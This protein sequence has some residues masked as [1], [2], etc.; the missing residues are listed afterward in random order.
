MCIRDRYIILSFGLLFSVNAQEKVKQEVKVVKPYEPVIG[1]AFKISELPK[2]VDT[3]KVKPS[4]DYEIAPVKHS[5]SFNPTPIK[6]ARLISEPLSKLY[7]GYAKAGFGSYLSPLAEVYVGSKRS[8]KW[9]WNGKIHYN[10]SNGKIKNTAG[11]KVYAGLSNT[12]A[13]F[14]ASHFFKSEKTLKTGI[15][16]GN[17]I[18]YYYGFDP[19]KVSELGIDAPLL[20]ED[21]EHQ[22]LNIV[23][24]FAQLQ[25]NYLDSSRV[26][27]Q[28]KIN[29]QTLSG[30]NEL[31]EH[32]MDI[33]TSLDYFFEN[34]FI[35]ADVDL[36]YINNQGIEDSI[37]AGIFRFSPWVGAF[38]NKWRIVA[39]V[40]TFFDQA[41]EEYKFYPRIS[42]HYNVIDYFLIPYFELGGSY[43]ENSYLEI[44]N[45]NPFIKQNLGVSPSD[46]K[47]NMTFGFRGNISSKVAFNA[48]IDY[49]ITNNQYF[50]VIDTSSQLHNKFVTVS[51]TITRV[52]LLG[53]ISYKTSERLW[54]AVK[55]NYYKYTM[56][57]QLEPWHMPTFDIS[58]NARYRIQNKITLD[59]N[60][61]GIGTRYA[62]DFD[63]NNQVY[64]KE[65][66][67]I[68]DLNLGVEY[69]L[70]KLLSAF[71]HFNNISSVK[72]YQ[73]NNYATQRFNVMLGATYSF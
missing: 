58:L 14:N 29:W 34:E 57:S 19:A 59:V 1:D 11:N 45:K 21:I 13:A 50:F 32:K 54:L 44:Y 73:W 23:N 22:T 26:N 25:T 9:N 30:L 40:N 17:H 67:G 15:N 63:E 36:K 5:T 60:V 28:V 61:F 31:G 4:F 72:Y 65:L 10:S 52:R 43:N 20:K 6:P 48:K 2:I 7:Y 38:G 49:N 27:Y 37:N 35:G 56:G 64:A 18:N 53:E 62:R 12:Q 68:V 46:N 66:Q 33:S 55:G 51:D 39:G 8:E 71:A 42:M 3:L 70:T 41:N 69:R 16:Y 24:A 47:I